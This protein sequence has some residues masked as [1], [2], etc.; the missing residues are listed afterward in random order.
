MNKIWYLDSDSPER[1]S[2]NREWIESLLPCSRDVKISDGSMIKAEAI[3]VQCTIVEKEL[4]MSFNK[5]GCRV[6]DTNGNCCAAAVKRSK[7][8]EMQFKIKSS[9]FLAGRQKQFGLK[10]WHQR[11]AN[12]NCRLVRSVLKRFDINFKDNTDECCTSCLEG[13]QHLNSTIVHVMSE[14]ESC[15]TEGSL[16][17]VINEE[18]VI[19]EIDDAKIEE[20]QA[21]EEKEE[22]NRA[23][24]EDGSVALYDLRDRCLLNKPMYLEEHSMLS[25][26]FL[27][28]KL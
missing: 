4:K 16:E 2:G 19:I 21:R 3:G 27:N 9:Y 1:M 8:F 22:K 24:G 7:L 12:Q 20:N 10:E 23:G 26:V 14:E 18:E 15:K 17:D 11:L 25:A 13:K 6:F 28:E 5:S